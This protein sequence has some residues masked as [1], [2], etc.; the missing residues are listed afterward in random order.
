[1]NKD[2]NFSGTSR[3]KEIDLGVIFDAFYKV[4][5]K[6]AS[7]FTF[8]FV[9]LFNIIIGIFLT[10]KKRWLFFVL[11]I[12]AGLIATWS[13]YNKRGPQYYSEMT[14]KTN[15]GSSRSLY[16]KINFFN[17]LIDAG[18]TA[19]LCRIFN[20]ST[21]EA[22]RL[23]LFEI[24]PVKDPIQMAR[25]YKTTLLDISRKDTSWARIFKYR[26]SENL[27]QDHDFPL[28]RITVYSSSPLI[29]PNIQHSI[30]HSMDSNPT[31]QHNLKAVRD[32]IAQEELL[33]S[34]SL[35]GIDSL[36]TAYI[37]MISRSTQEHVSEKGNIVLTDKTLRSPE[38][39]LFDKEMM[40]KNELRDLKLRQVE[41][42]EILQVTSDLSSIG[43][44]RPVIMRLFVYYTMISLALVFVV[45]LIIAFIRYL[46]EFEKKKKKQVLY[47]EN[48]F[49]A[50]T[51]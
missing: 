16:Q 28:H 32:L 7:F 14:V 23:R 9:S 17:A 8:L 38:I 12:V 27:W 34:R 30:V 18:Q 26:D 46:N 48:A 36:R 29:S 25:L 37:T 11:A 15:F 6:I 47:N 13:D 19:E 49:L 4:T 40:L 5:R 1:M 22:S 31:L 44:R 35:K 43:T 33:L 20:I 24:A 3:E 21:D 42:M 39:E 51:N 2:P 50:P 41:Q 45:I 10:I